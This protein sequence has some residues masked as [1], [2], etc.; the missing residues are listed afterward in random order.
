MHISYDVKSNKYFAKSN[1]IQI[2]TDGIANKEEKRNTSTIL[3]SKGMFHTCS[4]PVG[5]LKKM[6]CSLL[7]LCLDSGNEDFTLRK[8]YF[9]LS[10]TF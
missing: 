4:S 7:K 3:S 8:K 9:V 2:P 1:D 5:S 10:E 6:H